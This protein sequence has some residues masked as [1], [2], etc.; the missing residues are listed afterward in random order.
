MAA[1]RQSGRGALSLQS[2]SDVE[3]TIRVYFREVGSR[4]VLMRIP[5]N[6]VTRGK[7]RIGQV[8]EIGGLY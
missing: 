4:G 7:K 1:I 5:N 6:N 8:V 3:E 2:I